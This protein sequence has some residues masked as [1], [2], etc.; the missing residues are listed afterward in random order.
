MPLN[1]RRLLGLLFLFSTI[2]AVNS[3][4][5]DN[6]A[7][8]TKQRLSKAKVLIATRNLTAAAFELEKVRKEANDEAA[9]NAAN[10]MLVG[11]YLEQADYT[12]AQNILEDSYQKYKSKKNG[13]Y[14][15]VVGQMLRGTRAQIERYNQLGMRVSDANLPPEVATDLERW[16]TILEGML[17][18]TKQIAIHNQ[19]T[20]EAYVLLEDIAN[21]RITV[22]RDDYDAAR[23]KRTVEDVRELV[24]EAQTKIAEVDET[25]VYSTQVVAQNVPQPT[26]PNVITSTV[27]NSTANNSPTITAN[28]LPTTSN[29]TSVVSNNTAAAKNSAPIV[30]GSAP[31]TENPTTNIVASLGGGMAQVE[32]P[33]EKKDEIRLKPVSEKVTPTLETG[34]EKTTPKVEKVAEKTILTP[35]ETPITDDKLANLGRE[36]SKPVEKPDVETENALSRKTTGDE[37]II[38]TSF[39]EKPSVITVGSLVDY[40]TRKV[41]PIYPQIAK[42]TRVS[43]IVRVEVIVDEEGSV[44]IV[45]GANGPELLK[46]AAT[47]AIKRWK[48]KPVLR[49]GQP[50]K[51]TG[52]INFNFTL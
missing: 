23:W 25:G 47:D 34:A 39:S 13:C 38:K 5:T 11:I 40:A 44:S 27:G 33:V 14:F 21:T 50:V 51:V 42:S 26:K 36:N 41:A 18:Q 43:G 52:F 4:Q 10:V 16:R 9:S 12:R 37:T 28:N 46:R 3:A 19:K 1:V 22:A 48:F 20:T 29:S 7:E 35:A 17:E 49:D 24:S 45:Q 30:I 2:S 31:K 6:Q 15:S 32:P 8:L